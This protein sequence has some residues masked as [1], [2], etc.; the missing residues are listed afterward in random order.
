M[1]EKDLI[2]WFSSSPW[3]VQS[4]SWSCFKFQKYYQKMKRCTSCYTSL[5]IL[6]FHNCFKTAV[7]LKYCNTFLKWLFIVTNPH[8]EW[9]SPF[10][11]AP[12]DQTCATGSGVIVMDRVT[13]NQG[14]NSIHRE[15]LGQKYCACKVGNLIQSVFRYN[16]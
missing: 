12:N 1:R 10:F 9:G 2:F 15:K 7:I 3:K 14:S 11:L 5:K 4:L 8:S 13:S 16:R 6:S